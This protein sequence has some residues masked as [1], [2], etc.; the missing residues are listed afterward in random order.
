[1]TFLIMATHYLTW[2]VQQVGIGGMNNRRPSKSWKMQSLWGWYWFFL[3]KTVL[4][5]WRLTVQVLQP[6]Q[7]SPNNQEWM[8]N[9]IQWPSFPKALMQFNETTRY[10]TR[11]CWW[12][13]ELL[14]NGGI[15]WKGH[16]INS[17][18]GQITKIWNIL[19]WPKNW[20]I[21]KPIGHYISHTLNFL[22]T[23][24][25]DGVWGRQMH[26]CSRQTM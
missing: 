2:L 21:G 23:I 1:M 25:L 8:E 18:F 24:T 15:S 10:M 9:G 14:S 20:T 5:E 3:M 17:K 22:C 12:L 6:G 7:S 19:W 4:S 26:Y 11:K 13:F 16:V